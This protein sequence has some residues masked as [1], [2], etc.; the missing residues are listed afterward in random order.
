MGFIIG[1]SIIIL[2]VSSN[3]IIS[4][5]NYLSAYH[6]LNK[7]SSEVSE[8]HP[9]IPI[10]ETKGDFANRYLTS[11]PLQELNRLCQNKPDDLICDRLEN[12]DGKS[13]GKYNDDFSDKWNK[14]MEN[15]NPLLEQYERNKAKDKKN[16]DDKSEAKKNQLEL[17]I[18]KDQANKGIEK[19][20]KPLNAPLLSQFSSRG[21]GGL[22]VV[23][24]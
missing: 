9:V 8:R 16:A 10:K 3:L 23:F 5:G 12:N 21:N 15:L 7:V 6:L 24:A 4:N 22:K 2:I 1:F 17:K 19:L 13:K 11:N 18:E 20:K 14:R